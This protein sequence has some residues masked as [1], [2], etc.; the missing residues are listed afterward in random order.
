MSSWVGL[1]ED[2]QLGRELA[3]E[4]ANWLRTD[5]GRFPRGPTARLSSKR[6]DSRGASESGSLDTCDLRTVRRTVGFPASTAAD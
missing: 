2:Q 4:I 6:I 5:E 1:R 3:V